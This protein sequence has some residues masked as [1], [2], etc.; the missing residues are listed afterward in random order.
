LL[1]RTEIACGSIYCATRDSLAIITIKI[2]NVGEA[3][4]KG[5]ISGSTQ[6]V[7]A[8]ELARRGHGRRQGRQRA[9][10]DLV[11]RKIGDVKIPPI[12]GIPK[13]TTALFRHLCVRARP[14]V[15]RRGVYGAAEHVL[16]KEMF[17][18]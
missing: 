17:V 16:I 18:T 2:G 4:V 12:D 5:K 3:V 9:F 1:A 15:A 11:A 14:K 10:V 6:V 13:G 7:S 8:S